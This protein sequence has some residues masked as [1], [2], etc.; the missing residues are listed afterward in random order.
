MQKPTD[1][2]GLHLDDCRVGMGR[3]VDDRALE[4]MQ[5]TVWHLV[6]RIVPICIPTS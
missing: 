5:T 6:V 2:Y 4:R 1:T 3:N